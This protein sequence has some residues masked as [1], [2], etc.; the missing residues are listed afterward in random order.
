[1]DARPA[2]GYLVSREVPNLTE[3]TTQEIRQAILQLRMKPGHRL[4]EREL[5]EHTRTS[6]TCVRAALQQLRAE[7]LVARDPRGMLT[8][9]SVSPDEA[10]QI[11]EVRAALESAM[12]RLCV[13]RA[14]DADV[15]ALKAAVD[16][17]DVAVQRLDVAA[18]VAA[19]NR[20][21]DALI[22][23]SGNA[24]AHN[25]LATLMT[26]IVYLRRIT[27]E[28]ATLE[29]ESETV[30]LLRGIQRAVAERDADDAAQRSEAFV[31]RSA[32]FAQQVLAESEINQP[33]RPAS[34]SDGSVQATLPRR[35]DGR[36]GSNPRMAARPRKI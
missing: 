15:A 31:A 17:M 2:R 21:F 30:E 34:G 3:R 32:W 36:S 18:N 5:A 24:M 12:A 8:V 28:R 6:R 7:G 25:L 29:Y 14:S 9:A 26:R 33:P 23:G 10:R 27:A 22:R 16:D 4:V 35:S 20:F 13:A 11:Y 19:T 1:V